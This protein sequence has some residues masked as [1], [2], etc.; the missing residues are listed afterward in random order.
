MLWSERETEH[1]MSHRLSV[2][3]WRF[4]SGEDAMLLQT[5]QNLRTIRRC[6]GRQRACILIAGVA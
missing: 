6:M 1:V 3:S 2:L 5:K 4:V